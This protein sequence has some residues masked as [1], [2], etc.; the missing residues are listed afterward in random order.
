MGGHRLVVASKIRRL[1]QPGRLL[2]LGAR[3]RKFESCIADQMFWKDK[4]KLSQAIKS[5]TNK[6]RALVAL[7]LNPK[8]SVT[9]RK[10]NQ[11]IE[12]FNLDTSH[13]YTET[14]NERWSILPEIIDNCN[15]I[16]DVLKAVGLTDQG[17]NHRTAKRY[18]EHFNLNTDHFG[19]KSVSRRKY[20][21][22]EIFCENS[23]VQRSVVRAR[24]L[25]D[26]LIAYKC[27]SCG[28]D[29]QW[30][31]VQLKLELDHKNGNSNDHRLENLHFLCPNCHSQTETFGHKKRS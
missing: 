24:V 2:A 10:L 21:N 1:G 26:Q 5:S 7:G 16:G 17:S 13:F 9:R 8:G 28:N 20:T 6:S 27:A 4:E 18:I 15:S 31:G 23:P 22:K 30:K 14:F 11:A 12:E 29:G 19:S 25:Y 3:G